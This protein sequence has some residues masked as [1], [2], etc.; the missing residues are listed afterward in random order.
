LIIQAQLP[1]RNDLSRQ[2]TM[3]KTPPKLRLRTHGFLR[4]SSPPSAHAETNRLRH[5]DA[6]GMQS[7]AQD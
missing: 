3:Q 5:T 2:Q 7:T 6:T 4:L 1:R